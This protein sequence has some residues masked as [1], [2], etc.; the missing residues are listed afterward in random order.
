MT[1]KID[2]LPFIE[3]T[4]KNRWEVLSVNFCVDF[5]GRQAE[6]D[7]QNLQTNE[8]KTFVY[9]YHSQ[10]FVDFKGEIELRKGLFSDM[11]H[12]MFE[13][14]DRISKEVENAN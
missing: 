4:E 3:D 8:E 13:A 7:V 14:F 2:Y 5:G 10:L 12:N 11:M 9:F 1:D 6:I